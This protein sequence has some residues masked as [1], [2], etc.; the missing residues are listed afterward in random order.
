M[1]WLWVQ[2]RNSACRDR[3]FNLP[4]I[5]SNA[6]RAWSFGFR[7]LKGLTMAKK[8]AVKKAPAKTKPVAKAAKG[9]R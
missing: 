7:R 4:L 1:N 3:A 6:R 2:I 8:S 9:K 5:R